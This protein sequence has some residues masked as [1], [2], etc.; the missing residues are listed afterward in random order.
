METNYKKSNRLE[1]PDGI[2]FSELVRNRY[3]YFRSLTSISQSQLQELADYLLS[4]FDLLP[5]PIRFQGIQPH[6]NQRG[7]ST[8]REK[9]QGIYH[10]RGDRGQNSWIEVYKLT[11][12]RRQQRTPKGAIS[13]LLHEVMHHID[14]AW[15]GIRSIHC[16]GFY[17][18]LQQLQEMLI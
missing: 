18:R 6:K 13:T 10:C 16:R 14:T 8:M 5:I 11:A 7:K 4:R 2:V 15:F 12:K 9:T 1:L 3:A 17:S